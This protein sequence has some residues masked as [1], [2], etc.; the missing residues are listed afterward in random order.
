MTG[1]CRKSNGVGFVLKDYTPGVPSTSSGQALWIAGVSAIHPGGLSE[2]KAPG[3][4]L[5]SIPILVR[6][7]EGE[8]KNAIHCLPPPPEA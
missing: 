2:A 7:Q 6:Q 4:C 1:A 8:D 3:V 5:I